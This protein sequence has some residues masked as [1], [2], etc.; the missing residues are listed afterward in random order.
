M[1]AG[2]AGG[3]M[4]GTVVIVAGVKLKAVAD[5]G[6]TGLAV[7]VATGGVTVGCS[8]MNCHAQAETVADSVVTS[9]KYWKLAGAARLV[10]P[11]ISLW[12]CRSLKNSFM[13][14]G[15]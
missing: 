3:G 2:T 10:A 9:G 5:A 15:F 14:A 12:A 6:T 1:V 11:Y 7:G 4:A 8:C 13:F